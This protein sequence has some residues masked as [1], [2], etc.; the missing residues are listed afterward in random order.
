MIEQLLGIGFACVFVLLG[1]LVAIGAEVCARQQRIIALLEKQTAL[2]VEA[3]VLGRRQQQPP[4][5]PPLA[6]TY[7]KWSGR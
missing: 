5:W 7:I 2:V 4:E 3:I 1:S 6:D